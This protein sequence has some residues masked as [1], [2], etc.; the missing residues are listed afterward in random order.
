MDEILRRQLAAAQDNRL[1]QDGRLVDEILRCQL[2]AAQDDK[3][4]F[5]PNLDYIS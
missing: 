5:I 1:A 2:A 3:P 4:G